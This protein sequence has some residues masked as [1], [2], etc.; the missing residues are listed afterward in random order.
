M[1]LA[2]RVVPGLV[3]VGVSVVMVG[4]IAY[5]LVV[6]RLRPAVW[7]KRVVERRGVLD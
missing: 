3:L 2:G 4:V 6:G 7:V 5:V 1:A